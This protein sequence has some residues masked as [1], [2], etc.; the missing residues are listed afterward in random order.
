MARY[1]ALAPIY[2]NS[3]GRLIDAGEEFTSDEAPGL[4]W[5]PLD[6]PPATAVA[7]TTGRAKPTRK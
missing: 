6:T 7:P 2:L 4:A 5:I 3:E 1:R